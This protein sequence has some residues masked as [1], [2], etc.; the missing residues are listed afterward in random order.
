[1]FFDFDWSPELLNAL[2]NPSPTAPVWTQSLSGLSTRPNE[3]SVMSYFEN[4]GCTEIVAA[5]S[6][7]MNWIYTMLFPRLLNLL[8]SNE[9]DT[10]R[11]AIK[12]YANHSLLRLSFVHRANTVLD[13]IQRVELRQQAALHKRQADY[14]LIMAKVRFAEESWKS[15]EYLMAFFTACMADVS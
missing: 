2:L 9:I 11:A 5:P 8:S 13:P 10:G 15:E 3:Q 1:L 4:R 12:E 7:R 6:N 14:S